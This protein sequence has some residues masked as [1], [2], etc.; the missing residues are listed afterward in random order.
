M[1][2]RKLLQAV[3]RGYGEVVSRLLRECRVDV[4]SP[5]ARDKKQNTALMYACH[6]KRADLVRQ[7]LEYKADVDFHMWD[8]DTKSDTV[9]VLPAIIVAV[10]RGFSE[11]VRLLLDHKADCNWIPPEA[12]ELKV[13][14][15]LPLQAAIV[16][17]VSAKMVK[18]LL[19]HKADVNAVSPIYD[20]L[21]DADD[22]GTPL[23]MACALTT[24]QF[25][26]NV[27]IATDYDYRKSA[28]VKEVVA[29]YHEREKLVGHLLAAKADCNLRTKVGGQTALEVAGS[30]WTKMNELGYDTSICR[31]IVS[32]INFNRDE[33][34]RD[35]LIEELRAKLRAAKEEFY[36]ASKISIKKIQELE[37][38]LLKAEEGR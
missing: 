3:R 9:T 4:N 1:Q 36:Q 18:V 14:G 24:E 6:H 5:L 38:A 19:D 12:D 25:V 11:G 15:G 30:T 13:G 20:L 10:N 21:K 16:E 31:L 7:L 35:E 32:H 17:N 22:F 26:F 33:P 8:D 34:N 29:V 28:L 27:D 23:H 2:N 37:A